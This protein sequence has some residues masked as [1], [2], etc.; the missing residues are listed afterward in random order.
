MDCVMVIY[1]EHMFFPRVV[2]CKERARA[3]RKWDIS[4]NG[5][6]CFTSGQIM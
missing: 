3:E 1:D 2:Q 5:G 4:T 6:V